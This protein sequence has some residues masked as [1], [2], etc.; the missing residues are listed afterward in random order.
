[1]F[2]EHKIQIRSRITA[3]IPYLYRLESQILSLVNVSTLWGIKEHPVIR[4]FVIHSTF[5][6]LHNLYAMRIKNWKNF[7]KKLS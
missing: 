7:R 5:Y 3:T 2:I 4:Q 6:F 1:M